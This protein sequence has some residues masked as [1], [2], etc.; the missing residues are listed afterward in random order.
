MSEKVLTLLV[1]P[2]QRPDLCVSCSNLF[3]QTRL[4]NG[5]ASFICVESCPAGTYLKPERDECVPC[6]EH[7]DLDAGC[8]GPLPYVDMENGCRDCSLIQLTRSGG[9]VSTKLM[10]IGE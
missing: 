4:L 1:P 8:A 5:N 3:V 10:K 2:F 9:Q 7:C 6:Y